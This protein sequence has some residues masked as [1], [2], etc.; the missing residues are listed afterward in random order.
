M[1]DEGDVYV[2]NDL[3]PAQAATGDWYEHVTVGMLLA[4]SDRDKV[5]VDEFRMLVH[6]MFTAASRQGDVFS[7]L[8]AGVLSS[9]PAQVEAAKGANQAAAIALSSASIWGPSRGALSA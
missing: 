3:T 2:F 7:D 5:A 4:G 1:L 6:S 8:A 9:Q